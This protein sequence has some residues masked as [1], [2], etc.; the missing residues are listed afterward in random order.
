LSEDDIQ[1][2]W[3]KGE[4]EQVIGNVLGPKPRRK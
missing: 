3:K 2:R 1:A 4:R